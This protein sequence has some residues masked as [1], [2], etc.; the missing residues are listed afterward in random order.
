VQVGSNLYGTTFSGGYG[1]GYWG[2]VFKFD[3]SGNETLFHSFA[4]E[5]TDGAAP[6][7]A[8]ISD[9][10][11]N[12]YGTTE[13]GGLFDAGIVFMLDKTGKESVLHSFN[14][15]SDG[16]QPEGS[17]IRD[18]AGNLYG[19]TYNGGLGRHRNGTIFKITP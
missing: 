15:R 17:L 12:L 10:A 16:W 13:A 18:A 14:T 4:G 19:T 7:A 5:A 8:L 1:L 2:T 9:A 6:F 3:K 11:G